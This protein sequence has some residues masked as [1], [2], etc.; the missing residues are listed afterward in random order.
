MRS[1]A[2]SNCHVPLFGENTSWYKSVKTPPYIVH[3]VSLHL[4]MQD[5]SAWRLVR[6]VSTTPAITIT[7][8]KDCCVARATF[9]R[10]LKSPHAYR[11]SSDKTVTLLLLGLRPSPKLPWVAYSLVNA[12]QDR[13]E[14]GAP[15][16]ARGRARRA[17]WFMATGCVMNPRSIVRSSVKCLITIAAHV[18][19]KLRYGIFAG[20]RCST[21][22]LGF[23]AESK[24]QAPSVHVRRSRPSRLPPP[25]TFL[26]LANHECLQGAVSKDL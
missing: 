5:L 25:L 4:F 9:S 26:D 7:K 22:G 17:W 2:F 8:L 6:T 23:A 19:A 3:A 14:A 21:A 11:P 18:R 24:L 1:T 16:E 10:P 12:E 20:G 15:I 13:R